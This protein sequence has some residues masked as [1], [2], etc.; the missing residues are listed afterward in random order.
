MILWFYALSFLRDS[1][2]HIWEEHCHR[3]ERK[4]NPLSSYIV[5]I[6][7]FISY[8]QQLP[9]HTTLASSPWW[10][11]VTPLGLALHLERLSSVPV[12]LTS[13]SQMG[14]LPR[15]KW[16][17]PGAAMATPQP[18][19]QHT[20]LASLMSQ[21][22]SH[23]VPHWC[24]SS[25]STLPAQRLG[26]FTSWTAIGSETKNSKKEKKK[27]IFWKSCWRWPPNHRE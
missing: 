14:P 1:E 12:Q 10:H 22:S 8:E 25:T 5:S 9:E 11:P 23:T 19:C 7:K 16:A 4:T 6:H 18:S 15:P 3:W 21:L 20:T 26:P 17:K 27:K 24:R 2:I 13:D